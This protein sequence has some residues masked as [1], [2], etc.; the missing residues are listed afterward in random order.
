MWNNNH[1]MNLQETKIF[2]DHKLITQINTHSH[3]F[4]GPTH[5]ICNVS[6]FS[7]EY[8]CVCL[9]HTFT[10]FGLVIDFTL[11]FVGVVVKT[12]NSFHNLFIFLIS[13]GTEFG[14]PT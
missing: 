12:C 1:L 3:S 6:E 9:N 10:L 13:K 4:V 14:Y 7:C 2:Y 11:G 8:E 5:S